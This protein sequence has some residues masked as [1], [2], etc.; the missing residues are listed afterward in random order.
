MVRTITFYNDLIYSVP[1][2]S[3]VATVEI[4][5]RPAN[6]QPYNVPAI[7]DTGA[8]VTRLSPALLADFG[9]ADATVGGTGPVPVQAADNAQADGYIH[10][11]PIEFNGHALD[12]DALFVPAWGAT[13]RNLLGLQGF[14]SKMQAGFEHRGRSFFYTIVS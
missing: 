12:I 11:V 13:Q 3:G 10:Q 9:I 8:A 14:F 6:G 4:K 1:V 2:G 7:L 5:I